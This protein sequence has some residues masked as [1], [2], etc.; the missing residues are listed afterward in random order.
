[1][2]CASRRTR[3][4]TV[5]CPQAPEAARTARTAR[6]HG[7]FP[8]G[9]SSRGLRGMGARRSSLDTPPRCRPRMGPAEGRR[10]PGRPLPTGT[11]TG[12]AHI[13]QMLPNQLPGKPLLPLPEVKEALW[14]GSGVGSQQ[15]GERCHTCSPRS[16]VPWRWPASGLA[17]RESQVVLKT[18]H[19]CYIRH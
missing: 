14:G 8:T 11:G 7:H 15:R 5:I 18:G 3:T 2:Y 19:L 1:M 4:R 17:L 16:H 6:S 10:P 12:R 13:Q 9:R